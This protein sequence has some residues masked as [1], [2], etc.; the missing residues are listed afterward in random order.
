[1]KRKELNKDE[2]KREREML[3]ELKK[4][5]KENAHLAAPV[6]TNFTKKRIRVPTLQPE[7]NPFCMERQLADEYALLNLN[8]N[9]RFYIPS[10]KNSPRLEQ[11]PHN[12]SSSA[13]LMASSGFSPRIRAEFSSCAPPISYKPANFQA[14]K[15]VSIDGN[16]LRQS[17]SGGGAGE[18]NQSPSF[19]QSP[20][21]FPPTHQQYGTKLTKQTVT[22]GHRPESASRMYDPLS[23][24]IVRPNA[25][26][27]KQN[28]RSTS[29]K[30]GMSVMALQELLTPSKQIQKT[31]SDG[32]S[33]SSISSGTSPRNPPPSTLSDRMRSIEQECEQVD[34]KRKAQ[35]ELEKGYSS[36]IFNPPR[37]RKPIQFLPPT[38]QTTGQLIDKYRKL[39]VGKLPATS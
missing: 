8:K 2:L 28:A 13:D 38:D 24:S 23:S 16:D 9:P 3:L 20:R 14:P 15:V 30:T 33:S 34:A 11:N 35:E 39:A 29:V 17:P 18:S 36:A 19:V 21:Y 1:M 31:K 27:N 37:E 32:S 26:A 7:T 25:T 22:F 4:F 6:A 12:H 5:H 10:I